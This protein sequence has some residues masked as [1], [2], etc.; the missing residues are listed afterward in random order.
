MCRYRTE[1]STKRDRPR[2]AI[3][4]RDVAAKNFRRIVNAATKS[5]TTL[6]WRLV[7]TATY[8]QVGGSAYRQPFVSAGKRRAMAGGPERTG[9]PHVNRKRKPLFHRKDIDRAALRHVRI[10][11]WEQ[12]VHARLHL[13]RVNAPAGLDCDVL[14]AI[15]PKRDRDCSDA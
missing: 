3:P 2:V 11:A 4:L 9:A 14:F 8:Q 6:S 5:C 13:G 15:E 10:L 1:S 12:Q 7:S